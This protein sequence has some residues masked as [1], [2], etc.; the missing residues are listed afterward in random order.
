M[1]ALQGKLF[2]NNNAKHGKQIIEN[3]IAQ[4]KTACEFLA[5]FSREKNHEVLPAVA[6]WEC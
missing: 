1:I 2:R 3:D 4:W 5:D 6:I